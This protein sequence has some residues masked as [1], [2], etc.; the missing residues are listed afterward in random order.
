MWNAPDKPVREHEI[1]HEHLLVLK[2]AIEQACDFDPRSD[3][4]YAAL[5]AVEKRCLRKGAIKLYRK[6][7]ESG[8]PLVMREGFDLIGKHMGAMFAM[9]ELTG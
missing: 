8:D 2:R 9:D 5:E 3:E 4:V 7:L 6:G 1:I